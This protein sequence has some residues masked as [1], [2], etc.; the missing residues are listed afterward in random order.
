M[1]RIICRQLRDL[2]AFDELE[3]SGSAT[4]RDVKELL[5]SRHGCSI[6]GIRIIFN[7]GIVKDDATLA[8]FD[9]VDDSVL[10]VYFP[11]PSRPPLRISRPATQSLFLRPVRPHLYPSRHFSQDWSIQILRHRPQKVRFHRN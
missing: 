3:I 11:K 10:T 5:S 7:R 2:E 9:V 4:F 1:L 6:G 8:S